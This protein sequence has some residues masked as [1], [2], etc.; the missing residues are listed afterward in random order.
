MNFASDFAYL[1]LKR[2][3]RQNVSE[4]QQMGS[5]E[6]EDLNLNIFVVT[7]EG[8]KAAEKQLA[9]GDPYQCK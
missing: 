6:E 5:S 1:P 4:E 9:G 3:A 8:V 2:M 7:F